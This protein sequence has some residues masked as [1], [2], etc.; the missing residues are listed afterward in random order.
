L[1]R[2]KFQIDRYIKGYLRLYENVKL[3]M[4]YYTC[5]FYFYFLNITLKPFIKK[6]HCKGKNN[7]RKY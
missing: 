3:K 5:I 4:I 1:E 2:V 7:P 6:S